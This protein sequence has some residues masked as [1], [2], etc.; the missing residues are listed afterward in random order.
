MFGNFSVS[1]F[2]RI[3]FSRVRKNKIDFRNQ[4]DLSR[5]I[6]SLS[7]IAIEIAPVRRLKPFYPTRSISAPNALSRASIF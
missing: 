2:N 4:E 5:L 7:E 3:V 1:K 6:D